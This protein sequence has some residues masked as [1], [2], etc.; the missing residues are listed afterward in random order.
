MR[1]RSRAMGKIQRRAYEYNDQEVAIKET[2]R[3][4][5]ASMDCRRKEAFPQGRNGNR[6]VDNGICVNESAGGV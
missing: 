1:F 2:L 5:V 6:C 3:A 4:C